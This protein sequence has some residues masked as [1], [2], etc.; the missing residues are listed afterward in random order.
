M[1]AMR[2]R[3]EGA[4]FTAD[5]AAREI[6]TEGDWELWNGIAVL[7]DPAGGP[8]GPLGA[9][10]G[11][12]LADAVRGG[13]LGWVADASTGYLLKRDPDTLLAPDVSFVSRARLP[14]W[15]ESGFV[16]CAPDLAAE[17]RSPSDSW[18]HTIERGGIWIAH[19]VRVVWLVDPQDRRVLTL[20]PL[21]EPLEAG[22]G[23]SFSAAPVLDGLE[24]DVDALFAVLE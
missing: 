24:I 14:E 18:A 3:I 4:L 12:H 11:H 16:P 17:I 22:S 6:K 5:R 23:E 20:R 13:R 21:E 19:G 10:L 8:S 1:K 9:A 15:P 2:R 7:C